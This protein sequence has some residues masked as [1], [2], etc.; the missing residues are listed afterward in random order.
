MKI[1]FKKFFSNKSN[2]A[3]FVILIIFLWIQAP[4]FWN[5]YQKTGVTLKSKKY[6][7]LDATSETKMKNFPPN[8]GRAIAIFWATWCS[9]CK[10][11]MARL[12]SSV[13]SGS[14][15]KDAIFAINLNEPRTTVKKFIRENSYPFIF[16]DAPAIAEK[17]EVR[18]TPTTVFIEN[19]RVTSVS[20]GM[21]ILGIWRAELFL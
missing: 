10:M 15:N 16:I 2:I 14:I 3:T 19:E 9:P 17:L 8:Q 18:T 7:Q 11:E 20:S 5:N 4:I 1:S 13:E 12:K 6:L 21:S